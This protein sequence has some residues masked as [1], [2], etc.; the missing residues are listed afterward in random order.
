VTP[1]IAS[2]SSIND[3]LSGELFIAVSRWEK[4]Q[5]ERDEREREEKNKHANIQEPPKTKSATP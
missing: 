1:E 2:Q 3:P 5:R 4:Q